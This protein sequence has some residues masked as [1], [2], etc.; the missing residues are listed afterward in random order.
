MPFSN[1]PVVWQQHN[2]LHHADTNQE[3]LVMFTSNTSM[4]INVMSVTLT[5]ACLVVTDVSFSI[6]ETVDLGI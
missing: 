6:L 2:A 1:Q 3:L 5:V 4:G